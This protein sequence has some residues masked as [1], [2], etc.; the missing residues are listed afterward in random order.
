MKKT[1][2]IPGGAGYIGSNTA[3]LM[4][5]LGYKVIIVDNLFHGQSFNH[6]W[7]EFIKADFTDNEVLKN[8]FSKN[9]IDAVMH[10]AALIEV[11]ESVKRPRDFYNNNVIKTIKLLNCMVDHGVK[12]IVFSS[13]CAVYGNPVKIPLDEDNPYNPIS[14]YGKNK[15]CIEFA[16]KDYA[17]AYDLQYV[18]LRYF[19]AAGAN[20]KE[21]LGEQHNPETHII[22]LMLR[23]IKNNKI[24]KIF[25]TNYKTEDGT[26]VRD[27]IHVKDLAQAHVLA[28][29]YLDNGGKSNFFN[30]G[31]E[32][33][34]SVKQMIQAAQ[35]ICNKEMKIEICDRR[36]GDVDILIADSSK[37][38]KVLGWIPKYSD[39]D[40]ILQTAWE[41][42]QKKIL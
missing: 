4:Y 3:Y 31:S 19:N 23:A 34:Y 9:K 1:I 30:L 35:K 7:A 18:S 28:L 21:R 10:F 11:G 15:L 16:L 25:G 14:P 26:C 12:K 37:I 42:E 8:I 20:I 6:S 22:P 36:P 29:K 24:F 41:W 33:G 13:S 38:K 27:Y 5:K 40:F 2:L 32:A 17:D 39:L